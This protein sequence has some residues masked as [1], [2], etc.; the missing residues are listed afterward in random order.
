MAKREG[1]IQVYFEEKA[2]GEV[3]AGAIEAKRSVSSFIADVVWPEWKEGTGELKRLRIDNAVLANANRLLEEGKVE[4][5]PRGTY[6]G[7]YEGFHDRLEALL[8]V[9]NDALRKE[10]DR[11]FTNLEENAENLKATKW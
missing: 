10:L 3:I 4:D 11:Y 8:N 9:G 1:Q 6:G 5:V 2:K 7:K